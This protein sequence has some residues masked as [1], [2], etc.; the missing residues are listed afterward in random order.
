VCAIHSGARFKLTASRGCR[1]KIRVVQLTELRTHPRYCHRQTGRLHERRSA[2]KS[3]QT[4]TV[5]LGSNWCQNLELSHNEFY[6]CAPTS[7]VPRWP[8]QWTLKFVIARGD[9]LSYSSLQIK[10][11]ERPVAQETRLA[12]STCGGPGFSLRK[13]WSL[14]RFSGFLIASNR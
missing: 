2:R 4:Y 1:A 13:E 6:C 8:C 12:R 9:R 7:L 3:T 14:S 11:P 5:S 10:S